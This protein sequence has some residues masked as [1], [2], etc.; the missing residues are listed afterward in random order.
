[1]IGVF[2]VSNLIQI[3]ISLIERTAFILHYQIKQENLQ[4]ASGHPSF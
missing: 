1:M 3:T 4:N 2:E